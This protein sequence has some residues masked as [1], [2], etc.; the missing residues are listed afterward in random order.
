MLVFVV[1]SRLIVSDYIFCPII[2]SN[3]RLPYIFVP[4]R[5]NLISASI[6]IPEAAVTNN[7]CHTI[8]IYHPFIAFDP[9]SLLPLTRAVSAFKPVFRGFREL[10]PLQ[11][12][13]CTVLILGRGEKSPVNTIETKITH[14]SSHSGRKSHGRQPRI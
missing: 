1:E 8:T 12:K 11:R 10:L 7:Q 6:F 3:G 5:W 14:S 9:C 4:N 2:T 13:I